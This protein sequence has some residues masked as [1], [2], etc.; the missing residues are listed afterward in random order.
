MTIPAAPGV[1]QTSQPATAQQ[2]TSIRTDFNNDG[3]ADL[4]IGAAFEDVGSIPEAGA[5][6]VLYGTAN[7]ASGTGSQLFTQVGGAIEAGDLFGA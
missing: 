1:A 4:A 3:F 7:E 2:D 5:V 6:T